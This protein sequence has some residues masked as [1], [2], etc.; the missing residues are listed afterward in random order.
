M[1]KTK[2]REGFDNGYEQ[3]KLS[4]VTRIYNQLYYEMKDSRAKKQMLDFLWE[5]FE[6][7]IPNFGIDEPTAFE[8]KFCYLKT[9][10]YRGF[11]IDFY[12]D[13]NGQQDYFYYK[14]ECHGCG[15][16]NLW[17]EEYM[18]SVIDHDLDDIVNFA[19][20]GFYGGFCKYANHEHTKVDFIFRG[21][22]IDTYDVDDNDPYSVEK[23]WKDCEKRLEKLF[24][25]PEFIKSEEE[26]KASGNLYLSELIEKM[27]SEEESKND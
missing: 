16:Y 14:G 9:V 2:Y 5:N 11:K 1:R 10:E 20:R 4:A 18:Q 19:E 6:E 25:D 27:N 15:A 8:K 24:Q 3:G 17:P 7:Y 26:R 23:I 12:S 22:L 13:D 21:E